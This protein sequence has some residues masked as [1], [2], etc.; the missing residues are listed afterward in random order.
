[1]RAEIVDSNL[2][3]HL[4]PRFYLSLCTIKTY[5]AESPDSFGQPSPAWADFA[6]HVDIPCSVGAAG[7]TEVKTPN[8]TT[9]VATHKIALAGCYPNIIPKMRAV[10]SGQTYDILLVEVDSHSKMTR[11]TTQIVG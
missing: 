7:G 3:T 10:V 2:L 8:M 1:M 5:A 9:A 11:L 4:T 6:S